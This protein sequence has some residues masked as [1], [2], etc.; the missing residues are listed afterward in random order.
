MLINS[1]ARVGASSPPC[2][3][4]EANSHGDTVSRNPGQRDNT[5]TVAANTAATASANPV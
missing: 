5:A 4:A 1:T 2:D 3:T